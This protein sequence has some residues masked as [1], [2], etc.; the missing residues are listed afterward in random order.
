MSKSIDELRMVETERRE[1]ALNLEKKRCEELE[2]N[3][4]ALRQSFV[5]QQ[6]AEKA[7]MEAASQAL[8]QLEDSKKSQVNVP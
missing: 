3:M 5:D 8:Q 7:K 1:N 2:S 4:A 6:G